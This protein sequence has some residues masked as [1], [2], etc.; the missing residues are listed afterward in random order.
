MIFAPKMPA[1]L[2]KL[3]CMKKSSIKKSSVSQCLKITEN[4]SFNDITSETSYVD[5]QIKNIFQFSHQE[6]TL[7]F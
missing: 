3:F 1:F 4:V 6:S 5:F 2:R 7:Q